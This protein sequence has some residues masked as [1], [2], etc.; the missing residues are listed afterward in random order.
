METTTKRVAFA[1]DQKPL[2]AALT[3]ALTFASKDKARPTLCAVN[4]D[5]VE[6]EG[7]QALRFVATDRY[8]LSVEAVP[9]DGAGCW[10]E[11]PGLALNRF[12]LDTA[13]RL[14]KDATKARAPITL[15]PGEKSVIVSS[16]GQTV[17]VAVVDA[18]YPNWPQ[19][20]T[21]PGTGSTTRLAPMMFAKLNKLR[22]PDMG[23]TSILLEMADTELKPVRFTLS[24]NSTCYGILM[25]T[26]A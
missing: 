20:I 11:G 2:L 3:N 9:C 6:H 13:M 17:S 12:A 18:E 10:P 8:A 25:P 21:T 23:Q 26:R 1:T 14:V 4:V 24:G 15:E 19:L 5:R 7:R 22:G 16:L